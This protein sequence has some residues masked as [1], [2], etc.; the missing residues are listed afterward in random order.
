MNQAANWSPATVP[1]NNDILIF[2]SSLTYS[3]SV[4]N[5]IAGGTLTIGNLTI[6]DTYTFTGGTFVIPAGTF[7]L[8]Y[9]ALGSNI[10]LGGVTLTGTWQISGFGASP[11]NTIQ[12]NISG[13][14]NL[15]IQGSYIILS[16]SNTYLG[17]TTLGT[18]ATLKAGGASAFSSASNVSIASGA[19]LDLNNFNS[20]IGTL[21]GVAGSAVSLGT[22]T[23]TI[24]NSGAI[25][26]PGTISPGAT[27]HGGGIA[28]DGAGTLT[29]SGNNTYSAL[30]TPGSTIVN[31]A[32]LKAGS[33]N[34]FGSYS[35]LTVAGGATL[36]LNNFSNT[37]G[38]INGAGTI[39]LGS[40]SITSSQG[41]AFSG[42]ING[43]G[44]LTLTASIL[45]L[46]GA[47]TYLGATQIQGGSSLIVN[48]LGSSTSLV[49]ASGGG[50]LKAAAP[51]TFANPI[52]LND[53]AAINTNGNAVTLGG[54]ISGGNA[55]T[56]AGAG[57]LTL[58]GLNNYT[59]AT[60]VTGG[61]MQAGSTSAFGTNSAVTLTNSAVLD[62]DSNNIT[63]GSLAGG[64]G[65]TV[66]LGTATLTINNANINNP[67]YGVIS[68]AGNLDLTGGTL[69]LMKTNTYLGTTTVQGGS[70]LN[71]LDLGSSTTL[72]F[73]TGG[74]NVEFGSDTSTAADLTINGPGTIGSNTFDVTISGAITGNGSPFNKLGLG[75]LTL[76]GA[77]SNA[78]QITIEGG[79]LNLNVASLGSTT[80]IVFDTFGGTLQ[81]GEAM[82]I[83]QPITLS[84][85]GTVDTNGYNVA[86]SNAIVGGNP[87][88]KAGAGMLTLSGANTYTGKTTIQGGTLN[89]TSTSYPTG[90]QLVFT[91]SGTSTFQAASAFSP[92]TSSI[93]LMADGTID[94][95][96]NA[97][98]ISGVI[99]GLQANSLNKAGAGVLTLSGA[100][101][102]TGPT[103]VIAGILQAG[104]ATGA[105][106]AFGVDSAVT[107]S[108]GSTL[109]L[110]NFDNEIRSLAGAAGSF[111]TL[112]TATLTIANGN[113]QTFAGN[114]SGVGG[115]LTLTSGTQIFSGTNSYT[116]AT[117]VNGGILQAGSTTG[118]ASGSAFTIASGAE[119]N[120][121]NFNN[122]VKSIAGA[123]NVALGSAVLTIANASGQ[124]FSGNISGAGG[125]TLTT[126]TQILSGT[127]NYI[128]VTTINGGILQA[129]SITAFGNNSAVNVAAGTL[130]L[131]NFNN[132]V[133]SLTGAGSVTFGSGRLTIAN[134]GGAT[135]A[136]N[137]SGIGGLSLTT[138]TQ[139]LSGINS[140]IGSTLVNGGTLRAGSTTAF[141]SGSAFTVA[142]GATLAFQTFANTVGVLTN[143]GTVTSSA[144]VSA[145]S[146][147]QNSNGALTLNFPA[148]APA[149]LGNV[150]TTGAI[151]LN[152][153]LTVTN[154]GGYAPVSGTEVVLLKSS[155]TGKQLQGS[156]SSTTLPFGSLSYDYS[157]NQ[158]TVGSGN[159]DS[160]WNAVVAGNWGDVANWN[161]ACAPGVS[162]VAADNDIAHFPNVA[163]ASVVVT[164]ANTPGT[165]PQSVTLH[166]L[167]FTA[168]TTSYIIE[169][170][171]GT[172]V[173]T[174]DGSGGTSNPKITIFAGAHTIDAPIALDKDARI[175]LHAGSLTLGSNAIVS[176]V[177]TFNL[178]EGAGSGTLINQGQMSPA[179]I[180]FEGNTVENY[181]TISPAGT[182]TISGLNGISGTATVNNHMTMISGGN[183]TIGSASAGP[184]QVNNGG[185]MSSSSAF[186]IQSGTVNNNS[187][188]RIY[189]ASASTLS[190]TGGS[191]VNSRGA[192][193][194]SSDAHLTFSAGS[195]TTSGQVQA[196][197]YT[198]SG[199]AN[200]QVGVSTVSSS[201]SV[202]S[203]GNATLGGSLVV[204]ALPDFAMTHGQTAD[205][206]TASSVLSTFNSVSFQ[207]F[208]PNAIPSLV[209]LPGAVQLDIRASLPVTYGG[210]AHVVLNSISQHNGFITTK[211]YQLRDRM[212]RPAQPNLAARSVF[213]DDQLLA[214]NEIGNID[215]PLAQA[216]PQVQ[217][218]QQQLTERV[219]STRRIP[220]NVY[221]GP[222]ASAGSVKTKGDQI[223]MG[224][225]S[226]GGLFGFDYVLPME[227]RR[228]EAGLGSIL[229]YRRISV[230]ARDDWGSST[231]DRMHGSLY[232][233]AVPK[234][235]PNLAL[236]GIVGF[237]YNWDH[238]NRFTGIDKQLT[239][240]GSTN[241]EIF[242]CLFGLE[243]QFT[244]G[245]YAAMPKNFSIIPLLTLQ[246]VFDQISAYTETGAGIY[247]LRID[248]QTPQSFSSVLG[249]RI[250]YLF[251]RP[252]FTLRTEIDAGWQLEYLNRSTAVGFTAFNVTSV[253]TT[254]TT[255]APGRN[256]LLLG[257]DLLATFCKGWQ[258]E[259][260][261]N[262]QLNSLFYDT[263]FY[264]GVGKEF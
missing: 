146:F 181:G 223:G 127:N 150:S 4:L 72:I 55:F 69:S 170:F 152:G 195:L 88:T 182:L 104:I 154:T 240:Q 45:T 243:Y 253:S 9:G 14:G 46:S 183:F 103:N 155:G 180:L 247:N 7:T 128:G 123:G 100:N 238:H 68:G 193:L 38:T 231:I 120:L 198:Q 235:I 224:H 177:G 211:S 241:E 236:E 210:T 133:G 184:T 86:I 102:Y 22:A 202:A 28:L 16:G 99:A 260:S 186:A 79:V 81:A 248:S 121:N 204:N 135:F 83:T 203:S 136:G 173:I 63:I 54:V 137:M 37:F 80:A 101:I 255:V 76:S 106:G 18:G 47:N 191:V 35:N 66:T 252:S 188:G 42:D 90:S 23:L 216:N 75:T 208:P 113:T 259:A 124:I 33:A 115:D 220:W 91:G 172:S 61:T 112:G 10:N 263:F 78:A 176:S 129:G 167:E 165:L 153:Q 257:I 82:T 39:N 122:T 227:E 229:E 116:G 52:T 171:D 245:S 57:V 36:N 1:V 94:T 117:T 59:G 166:D 74:G 109:D 132:T 226:V 168:S 43:T 64:V 111:V 250:D 20:T 232:A 178:S 140:Y 179:D 24:T 51:F 110:N 97:M 125:M 41:G 258:L 157:E 141:S 212:P 84:T 26:F 13:A 11:G 60:N 162:G 221:G 50:T 158:V 21:T 70:T 147:T 174:L 56:K 160:A 19:T 17:T 175:S 142:N 138:G 206:I 159:C 44:G 5:N 207:N 199:S 6:A 27:P 58:N 237:A 145:A 77:N 126:G 8:N 2:P 98:T 214:Q 225:Y 169:Q 209:Y 67:F 29:L 108:A 222:V 246:Y 48:Y 95:D 25:D 196:L 15:D 164:L 143:S 219:E 197:D 190:I 228:F 185:T 30:A 200:L 62:L 105:S 131:N 187:G 12:S 256:S 217:E 87:F 251:L 161:P 119:I 194:G 244:N 31:A 264:L 230:D 213:S 151:S 254:A 205:L 234:S 163:A 89:A 215:L 34:A 134:G 114:M 148:A 201:G 85:S 93:V 239:A 149:P 3:K 130:A 233:T 189:A 96:G 262:Y 139:I 65:S 49:F 242:D 249:T 92:M 261:G 218:K 53:N 144:A 107:L 118:F 192:V 71:T 32:T 73:S 40:A 156:F